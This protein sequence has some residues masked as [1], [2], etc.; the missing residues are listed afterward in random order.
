MT[1]S[2]IDITASTKENIVLVMNYLMGAET[3]DKRVRPVAEAQ[4]AL[5][6]MMEV[7]LKSM[8]DVSCQHITTLH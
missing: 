3:Y 5:D 1:S 8:F 6:V 4:Q 7:Q 2:S